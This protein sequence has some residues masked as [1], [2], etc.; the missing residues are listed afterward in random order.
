MNKSSVVHPDNEILLST[1]KKEVPSHE[2]TWRNHNC[3]LV[4]KEANPK[5]L[6]VARIHPSDI[7]E[8]EKQWGQRKDQRLPE[9]GQWKWGMNRA[10]K[11][12]RAVKTFCVVG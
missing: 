4:N 7:P 11:N 1:K 3:I 9:V 10:R 5:R 6:R 12:F 8:K 2:K